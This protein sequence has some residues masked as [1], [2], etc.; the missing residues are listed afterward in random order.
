MFGSQLN[1]G[2]G[3]MSN[4]LSQGF[5]KAARLFSTEV[6]ARPKNAWPNNDSFELEGVTCPPDVVEAMFVSKSN[7]VFSRF[8]F[9]FFFFFSKYAFRGLTGNRSSFCLEDFVAVVPQLDGALIERIYKLVFQKDVLSFVDF[10]KALHNVLHLRPRRARLGLIFMIL[11]GERMGD[12]SRDLSLEVVATHLQVQNCLFLPSFLLL[13][14]VH[15][16]FDALH[17]IW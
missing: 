2:L 7:V 16:V 9:F 13:L 4:S 12:L 11:V 17:G 14:S 6:M 1:D 8:L 3:L 10:V 15:A 5:V